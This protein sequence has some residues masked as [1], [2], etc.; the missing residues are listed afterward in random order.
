MTDM[1]NN[2]M[3]GAGGYTP[4]TRSGESGGW[5]AD[6]RGSEAPGGGAVE[7]KGAAAPASESGPERQGSSG[8]ERR[9]VAEPVEASDLEPVVESINAYL[10]NSQRTLEFSV[11]D[12]TGRTVITVMDGE[13][14]EIIRQ[15]P[16]EQM[17]VLAEH[18]ENERALGGTGFVDKA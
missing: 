14:D 8:S 15:I 11:D 9:E 5:R 12:S 4:N 13:S 7:R 17:L 10:Q 3:P 2:S 6:G 1:I 18:F 16:P